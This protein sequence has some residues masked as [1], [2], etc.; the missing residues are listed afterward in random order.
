[1]VH[2]LKVDDEYIL[3]TRAGKTPVADQALRFVQSSSLRYIEFFDACRV[4]GATPLLEWCSRQQRIVLEYAEEQLV[5][6]GVRSNESGAYWSHDRVQQVCREWELPCVKVVLQGGLAN[7]NTNIE[8]FQALTRGRKQEEGLVLRWPSGT[9]V[10]LKTDWYRSMHG[11]KCHATEKDIWKLVLQGSVDD[12]KPAMN[13][14]FRNDIDK[15]AEE[16]SK[17]LLDIETQ[18]DQDVSCWTFANG[19]SNRKKF[20]VEVV[21][22]KD[23][24]L[25]PFYFRRFHKDRADL[26]TELHCWALANTASTTKFNRMRHLF[27]GLEWKGES[28]AMFASTTDQSDAV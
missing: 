1:M 27:G 9:M 2:P 3:C 10:K 26:H 18:I 20:A 17:K 21:K 23:I 12:A 7:N 6:T 15:F 14:Q 28:W 16:L 25:K 19:G 13:E 5:V 22:E 11:I 24:G 8:E 4:Q